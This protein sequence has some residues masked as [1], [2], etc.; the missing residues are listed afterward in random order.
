MAIVL[1]L[2]QCYHF[3]VQIDQWFIEAYLVT[4]GLN[5]KTKWLV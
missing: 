5:S 2:F 4:L 3:S 1:S